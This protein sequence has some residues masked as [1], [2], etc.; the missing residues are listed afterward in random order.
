MEKKKKRINVLMTKTRIAFASFFYLII[1]H[2]FPAE[3]KR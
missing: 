1:I 3:D 2:N